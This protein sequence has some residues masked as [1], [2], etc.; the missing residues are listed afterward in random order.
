MKKIR[1]I[2]VSYLILLIIYSQALTYGRF[3]VK[4]DKASAITKILT[5]D[6]QSII[7]N[8]MTLDQG[9]ADAQK[10]IDTTLAQ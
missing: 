7:E 9:L 8:K 6:V 1:L 4:S 3:Y 5:A 10:Q 2:S